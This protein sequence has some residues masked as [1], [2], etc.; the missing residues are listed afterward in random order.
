VVQVVTE[1][2]KWCSTLPIMTQRLSPL[3]ATFL[4]AE[5]ATAA[6][7]VGGVLTFAAPESGRFD[8]TAFTELVGR[9]LALAPRLRQTVRAVPGRL[10]APV[11]VDDH[12]FDLDYHVRHLALP[13]PG[14][15]YLL[16]ELVGTLMETP[17]DRTRPLWEVCVV[18]GLADGRTALVAKVHHALADGMACMQLGGILLDATAEPRDTPVED[19]RPTAAPSDLSLAVDAA[20]G[21][22]RGTRSTLGASFAAARS[23]DTAML[24]RVA[25]S[26]LAVAKQA[27]GPAPV[28]ALRT[29]TSG[30]RCYGVLRATL[31]DHRAVRRAHGG[32]VNDVVLAVIAGGLRRWLA[33]RGEDLAPAVCVRAMVPVSMRARD[34]GA[35]GNGISAHL[36]DLPVGSADPLERLARVR[37]A[38]DE[39]KRRGPAVVDAVAAFAGALPPPLHELGARIAG[40]H[41]GRLFDVLVS[42]V[43]GP[44][45]TLYAAGA[46]L[47]DLFP[48]VPLGSGQAVAIG[49]ASYAGALH[50][51]IT[52]DSGAVPDVDGLAAAIE[53]A[54]A[55]LVVRSPRPGALPPEAVGAGS[56][57]L[58]S[59]HA[60]EARAR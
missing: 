43:P 57:L 35:T 38:M 49:V 4:Y 33:A 31:A 15:E 56:A 37:A 46:P 2:H 27:A 20:L 24:A 34:R 54:L 59:S 42:N 55:E 5:H 58:A 36:V 32:T 29:A 22:F 13:S 1:G 23:M 52:V 47:L 44:P 41:P 18:E 48:L 10:G 26:A 50:Y 11:W 51:G 7:H 28:P 17:L 19:W 40:R 25:A 53:E 6:M 16:R 3:D 14:T 45:R 21:A 30:R 9:R 60:E 8:V 12:R 39:R